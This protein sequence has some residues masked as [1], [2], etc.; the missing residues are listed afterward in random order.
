[1]T[2]EDILSALAALDTAP[3]SKPAE[4]A[5][6]P[7]PTH[8]MPGT[9]GTTP[10]TPG[11]I[12]RM[13]FQSQVVGMGGSD[14]T[15]NGSIRE[16]ELPPRLPPAPHPSAAPATQP[17]PLPSSVMRRRRDGKPSPEQAPTPRPVPVPYGTQ[18][19][20]HPDT[21]EPMPAAVK[22]GPRREFWASMPATDRNRPMREWRCRIGRRP[23]VADWA[24]LVAA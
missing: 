18:P 8:S 14:P 5:P 6:V 2:P 4:A 7:S 21:G 19:S 23:T 1:M 24:R 10:G 9:P 13:I 16:P 22:G 11:A 17:A 12:A 15:R 20:V 3:S